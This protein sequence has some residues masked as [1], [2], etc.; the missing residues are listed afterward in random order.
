MAYLGTKL[1][2]LDLMPLKALNGILILFSVLLAAPSVYPSNKC[3]DIFRKK[4]SLPSSSRL[5]NEHPDD[6]LPELSLE[7]RPGDLIFLSDADRLNFAAFL[8]KKATSSEALILFRGQQ[9]MNDR[10]MAIKARQIGLP[11]AEKDLNDEIDRFETKRQLQIEKMESEIAA[12]DSSRLGW[13]DVQMR[14]EFL[15]R[16]S[17]VKRTSGKDRVILNHIKSVGGTFFVSA[18]R[19][20]AVAAGNFQGGEGI[21]FVYVFQVPKGKAVNVFGVGQRTNSSNLGKE[22]EVSVLLDA[23]E[24]V[25]GVY[26][27]INHKFL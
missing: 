11:T 15:N 17:Y 21:R 19:S 23:T 8:L 18:T 2:L 20:L 5:W 16:L 26:D 1:E 6:I 12:R 22:A 3:E 27:L 4:G 9:Q 10:I 25:L 13:L 7:N 14:E 24:Y